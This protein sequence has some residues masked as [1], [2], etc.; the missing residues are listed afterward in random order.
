MVQWLALWTA[1][2]AIQVRVLV[3]PFFF[4]SPATLNVQHPY[5]AAANEVAA[6]CRERT[7]YCRRRRRR[8]RD[9]R[10]PPLQ[11]K[12]RRRR[13]KRLD[14]LLLL[15]QQQQQQQYQQHQQPLFS[16]VTNTYE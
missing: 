7:P 15:L 6:V 11:R 1:N 8:R 4:I 5:K 12:C 16:K 14:S 13:R 3:E 2:P 10:A 9:G